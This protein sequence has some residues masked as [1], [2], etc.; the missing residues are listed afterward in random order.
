M[1]GGQIGARASSAA[2][3]ITRVEPPNWW[4]G[5]KPDV[6]LLITGENLEGA[7]VELSAVGVNVK[8]VESRPG[9]HYIFLWMQIAETAKAGP[10][11]L[12][13]VAPDG[14]EVDRSFDLLRARPLAGNFKGLSQDDVIYLIMPDRF[15]DGDTLNDQPPQSPGTYDRSKLRAYHGGDLRGIR[16]HLDYLRDLGVTTL[17]LTPIVDNDNHS[18]ESYHGYAAVDEYAVEEHFGTLEELQALVAGAHQRGMKIFLDMVPNHVG[19]QHPWVRDA[20]DPDWFHGTLAHHLIS[21]GGFGAIADPHSPPKFWRD[22]E[23][24]WFANVLPDLNQENPRVSEYLIENALWWAKATGAD[25]Y[26]LDTF[27]Y[28]SRH[29]WSSWHR[30]LRAQFPNFPTIGEIFNPDASLTSFFVGEHIGWDGVDT[31]LTTCFDFPS[32]TALNDVVVRGEGFERL[33]DVLSRDHLYPHPEILVPFF[34]NHDVP[35]FL[36]RPGSSKQK[37]ELVFS[38]LLTMRG[39][40]QIYYGDEIGMQGGDDPDNRRDFPGGF[41]G[42]SRNAF[43][44]SGRTPDEQ[45]IFSHVQKLLRLR[46]EHPALRRGALWHIGFDHDYYAYARVSAEER[47]LIVAN[48]SGHPKEINMSFRDTPVAGAHRLESLQ[49][50]AGISSLSPQEDTASLTVP[51]LQALIFQVK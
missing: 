4:V 20:P 3:H 50:A 7:H 21:H 15:A 19:P 45:E 41:P 24:G 26:R 42:D 8:Q 40:P 17:W 34:D 39:I 25:G 31:G 18:P 22:V 10:L 6:M 2:P 51:A 32:A 13:V 29:F 46:R 11:R 43:L 48:N 49:E 37:L 30:E 44:A 23:Q 5:F 14:R 47:L 9:G 35:R 28:V 27:P 33:V 16:E 1:L 12:R 38:L 36:S